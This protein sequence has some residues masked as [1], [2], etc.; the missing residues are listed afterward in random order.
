QL[1]RSS[2]ESAG[3]WPCRS[4]ESA[5]FPISFRLKTL[6]KPATTIG[7][8]PAGDRQGQGKDQSPDQGHREIH[9]QTR[10]EKQNPE[11]FSLHD[12]RCPLYPL[13]YVSSLGCC[14]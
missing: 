8:P 3:V 4:C 13:L 12:S 6:F 1:G 14:R 11:D 7:D 2:K 10:A 5:I 9:H